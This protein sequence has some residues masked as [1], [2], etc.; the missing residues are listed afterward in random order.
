MN[1]YRIKETIDSVYDFVNADL[2]WVDDN[3]CLNFYNLNEEGDEIAIAT[4]NPWVSVVM[5][6]EVESED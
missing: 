1:T 4:F 5:M 2:Y 3:N 6:D